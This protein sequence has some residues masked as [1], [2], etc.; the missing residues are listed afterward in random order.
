VTVKQTQ[1]AA[2]PLG[3]SIVSKYSIRFV[4]G[5][6]LTGSLERPRAEETVGKGEDRTTS[7]ERKKDKKGKRTSVRSSR[8]SSTDRGK[9]KEKKRKASDKKRAGREERKKEKRLRRLLE[10]E[11]ASLHAVEV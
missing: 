3:M 2:T 9:K 5:G 10:K 8:E 11:M 4:P 1:T 7:K 6:V